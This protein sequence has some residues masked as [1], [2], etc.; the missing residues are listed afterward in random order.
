M[1]K[2]QAF[3]LFELIAVIVVVGI[4]GVTALARF[5]DLSGQAELAQASKIA[6]E[7][8]SAI[9]RTQLT[10]Y[11]QRLPTR[12]QNLQGFGDNN[13]DTNN[14]GLPIGIDKGN[15]NENIGRGR[16]GCPGL[17]EGLLSSYPS[18]SNNNNGAEY[19]AF[20]HTQNKVCSYVYRAGGDNRNRTQ[21]ALVIK[22]DSRDGN[23]V[24]CGSNP[25]L[26]TC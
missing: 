3:T 10:W 4:L 6:A 2:Q 16:A 23:V 1:R 11:T 5:Q 7:F 24:V 8:Q 14:I 18:V 19:Q 15:G 13:V 21:A 17:W 25:D 9:N 12:V 22:Y 20:R 26:P